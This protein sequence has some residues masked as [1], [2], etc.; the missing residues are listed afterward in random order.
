MTDE[1]KQLI[2]DAARLLGYKHVADSIYDT[3]CGKCCVEV[4]RRL[5]RS[6]LKAQLCNNFLRKP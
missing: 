4:E 6:L 5:G 2:E 1:L 3:S